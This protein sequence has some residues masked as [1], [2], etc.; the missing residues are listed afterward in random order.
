MI[1]FGM[2]IMPLEASKNSY[3]FPT[4]DITSMAD[5]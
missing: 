2:E 5:A 1:K 3:I 4:T